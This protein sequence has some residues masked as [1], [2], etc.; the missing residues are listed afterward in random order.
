[1]TS[2]DCV[3][4]KS[5][6]GLQ[7]IEQALSTLL[8]TLQPVNARQLQPLEIACNRVL[9]E[10]VVSSMDIPPHDNS[11]M[12]GYALRC[13]DLTAREDLK[14]QGTALAGAPFTEKVAP[15]HTVRIMTGAIIPS[16]A[17]AIVMQEQTEVQQGRIRF[18]VKPQCGDNIRRAGEDI[19]QGQCEIDAGKRLTPADIGVLAS[20]GIAQVNTF[21]PLK[22]AIFSTGDEL[23]L[24]GNPL[25]EGQIYDSNR[26][27]LRTLM[28]SLGIE[29]LDL[30]PIPDNKAALQEA[31]EQAT[32][33]D[34]MISS[35]GV[36]VGEADYTKDMLEEMGQIHFWKLAIKPGKPFAFG[37]IRRCAYFGLPGNPVSA[38]VTFHQLV[39]PALRKLSGQ[40]PRP[41]MLLKAKCTEP[42]KKNPGRMEFQRGIYCRGQDGALLVKSTGKQ[43]SGLMTSM[44]RANCYIL[45]AQDQGCVAEGEVVQIQPFDDLHW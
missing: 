39:L 33:C 12:D 13:A 37:H 21:R 22:V 25:K 34:A 17:D 32:T 27:A 44:A 9:A 28:Q 2:S 36:S 35:G 45:L 29:V 23:V 40:S 41:A 42:L 26:P 6:G 3:G 19:S 16:G 8:E 24:P 15:G 1:M 14:L 31:M 38:M 43:G 5:H 11:A 4:K 10:P 18:L 30:G 20:L 7:P